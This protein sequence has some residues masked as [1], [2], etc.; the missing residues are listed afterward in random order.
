MNPDT[1]NMINNSKST[2][3]INKE[4]LFERDSIFDILNVRGAT[5]P[6]KNMIIL[7]MLVFDKRYTY[8]KK[9]SLVEYR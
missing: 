9:L 8:L 6:G 2:I 5:I 1:Q 4:N 7:M 3:A